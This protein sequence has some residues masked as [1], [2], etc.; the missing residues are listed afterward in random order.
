MSTSQPRKPK[1]TP[2]GG[3]F[4][5]KS[6]QESTIVVLGADEWDGNQSPEPAHRHRNPDGSLG[7][8]VADTALV[9][10]TAFVGPDARVV[11]WAQ[12]RD[13][14]TIENH[15]VVEGDA[16]IRDNARVAGTARVSNHALVMDRAV[17]DGS[18]RI[19]DRAV[20]FGDAHISMGDVGEDAVVR[21]VSDVR[22]SA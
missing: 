14:A 9:E 18:A 10:E 8:W 22:A 13:F 5:S 6:R 4:A 20:V 15:A 11:G 19:E 12:V 3:Q 1:G 7:G 21:S 17:V 16:V 2:T